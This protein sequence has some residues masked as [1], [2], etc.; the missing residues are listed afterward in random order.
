MKSIK[1]TVTTALFAA[2]MAFAAPAMAAD[3]PAP[4][5]GATFA[6]VDMTRVLHDTDAAKAIVSQLQN[7]RK[8]YQGLIA[9]EEA[10]LHATNDELIKKKDTLSKEE[11]QSRGLALEK[12]VADWK[13][14]MVE[15]DHIL[16]YAVAD[17]T[18]ALRREAVKIVANIAKE[19]SYSAVFTQDAVMIST[20]ELDLTDLVI[21]Q[22]N[23]SV[24]KVTLDWNAAASTVSAA[25]KNA[26]KK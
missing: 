21:A 22:M 4:A 18:N 6:F 17:A 9:K 25:S 26:K 14:T 16:E 15:R 23:K 2:A 3:T 19:R 10:A 11:L 20:P 8:E 24:K 1:T 12:K 13:H 5:A 7:K